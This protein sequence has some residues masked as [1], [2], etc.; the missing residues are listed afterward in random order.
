MVEVNE[1][2]GWRAQGA[3]ADKS[4]HFSFFMGVID[5]VIIPA[6]GFGKA[7]IYEA[8]YAT[9]MCDSGIGWSRGVGYAVDRMDN[10]RNFIINWI[11]GMVEHHE[12]VGAGPYARCQNHRTVREYK[13]WDIYISIFNLMRACEGRG[14]ERKSTKDIVEMLKMKP[15]HRKKVQTGMYGV[16]EFH[17]QQVLHLCTL[18]GLAENKTRCQHVSVAEGT[19]TYNRLMRMGPDMGQIVN[20]ILPRLSHALDIPDLMVVENLVCEALRW[21]AA[22]GMLRYMK[23]DIVGRGVDGRGGLLYKIKNGMLYVGKGGSNMHV[24]DWPTMNEFDSDSYDP[25][26]QWWTINRHHPSRTLGE[27]ENITIVVSRRQ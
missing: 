16:G 19:E 25:M 24:R 22:D 20:C 4:V 13:L 6:F 10:G 17:A 26:M 11:E 1:F 9:T 2:E 3:H 12:H 18:A 21:F 14:N 7:V 5:N 23:Y 15:Y 27:D 8:I